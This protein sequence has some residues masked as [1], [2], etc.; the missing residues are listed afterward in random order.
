MIDYSCPQCSSRLQAEDRNVGQSISCVH[1]GWDSVV[2]EPIG[3]SATQLPADGP[4]LFDLEWNRS[5]RIRKRNQLLFALI[6][7][8]LLVGGLVSWVATR[9]DD[10]NR[11][12]ASLTATGETKNSFMATGATK[13]RS[14][15][16]DQSKVDP[17][18][19]LPPLQPQG[20]VVIPELPLSSPNVTKKPAPEGSA[21]EKSSSDSAKPATVKNPKE[22]N[23]LPEVTTPCMDKFH[24]TVT[25]AQDKFDKVFAT[26]KTTYMAKLDQLIKSATDSGELSTVI[27]LKAERERIENGQ[28]KADGSLPKSAALFLTDCNAHV[29]AALTIYNQEAKT[30]FKI[31]LGD[32]DKLISAET[33]SNRFESAVAIQ[34]LKS[35]YEKSGVPAIEGVGLDLNYSTNAKEDNKRVK[36]NNTTYNTA[37]VRT[38]ESSWNQVNSKS[39]QLIQAWEEVVANRTK[40]YLELRCKSSGQ[41]IRIYSNRMMQLSGSSWKTVCY[42]SWEPTP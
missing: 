36:W 21:P 33:K 24:A 15:N 32:L 19:N 16:N 41:T 9:K 28:S 22:T 26:A 39:G 20:I 13:D 37:M 38:N 10:D 11:A 34:S 17:F 7:P 25:K 30:A 23:A 18:E 12:S 42:G 14:R 2:P 8:L 1:C 31:F 4:V 27:A 5:N 40:D 3:T 29:R 35:A 6:F